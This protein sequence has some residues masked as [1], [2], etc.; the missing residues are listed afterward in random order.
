MCRQTRKSLNSY[1]KLQ[2][3]FA[4]TLEHYMIN[5]R[6]KYI[7]SLCIF[8]LLGTL[9]G[10]GEEIKPVSE[11]TRLADFI[12]QREPI[13]LKPIRALSRSTATYEETNQEA[14]NS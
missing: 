3:L 7:G 12:I 10:S 4:A 14:G 13:A 9:C 6:L 2:S 1:Q 8:G 11:I 5:H